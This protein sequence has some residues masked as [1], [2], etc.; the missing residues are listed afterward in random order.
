MRYVT[1][2]PARQ[3]CL[4]CE[5]LEHWG[6]NFPRCFRDRRECSIHE[7]HTS[8]LPDSPHRAVFIIFA[9]T[10]SEHTM[11]SCTS[12]SLELEE[13]QEYVSHTGS[14]SALPAYRATCRHGCKERGFKGRSLGARLATTPWSVRE[15][16]GFFTSCSEMPERKP[17]RTVVPR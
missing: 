16:L 7:T 8:S 3:D 13:I 17:V 14:C 15:K 2:S 4:V 11:R 10:Y 5:P 1:L 6:A 12:E 9:A